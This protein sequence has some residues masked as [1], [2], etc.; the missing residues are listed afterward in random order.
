[1]RDIEFTSHVLAVMLLSTPIVL[2]SEFAIFLDVDESEIHVALAALES[3]IAYNP[4]S[5]EF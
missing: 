1:M 3:V 5:K 4:Q 2:S